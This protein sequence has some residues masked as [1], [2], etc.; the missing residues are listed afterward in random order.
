MELG[1]HS[2]LC[3]PE[4]L[5][6]SGPPL[7]HRQAASSAELLIEG[8]SSQRWTCRA[9]VKEAETGGIITGF[10]SSHLTLQCFICSHTD[11]FNGVKGARS[12]PCGIPEG[13]EAP[14]DTS[15]KHCSAFLQYSVQAQG[16]EPLDLFVVNSA[17]KA[18]FSSYGQKISS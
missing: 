10:S 18:S 13:A 15:G 16:T 8:S 2:F 11:I 12:L 3:S 14:P 5:W 9:D 6:G 7:C 1:F 4:A 17:I